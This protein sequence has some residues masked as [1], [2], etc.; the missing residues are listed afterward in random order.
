MGKK[1]K[2]PLTLNLK[3]N[4]IVCSTGEHNSDLYIIYSGMLTVFA[5]EGTR[6]TPLACLGPGEYFGE[7]SFIDHQP[8]SANVI[9]AEDT[10]LVKI[11]I[12]QLDKQF[13]QWLQTIAQS[14]IAKIRKSSE[15]INHKGI[16]KQNVETMKPLSIEEQ[17]D[18]YQKVT[19]YRERIGLS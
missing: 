2:G 6:V 12:D 10:T 17:R 15:L 18:H 16:R 8:R 1:L 14:I 3:K 11:P 7:L 13:P 9:C 4:D 5:T 19:E